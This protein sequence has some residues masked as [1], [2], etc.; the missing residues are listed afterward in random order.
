[1]TIWWQSPPWAD[2]AYPDAQQ[3]ARYYDSGCWRRQTF[4]DDL[5][6]AARERGEHPAIVAYQDGELA[7]SVT[8]AE[9]TVLVDRFAAALLEL[10]AGPGSIVLLYLPNCWQLS[11]LYLACIRIGAVASPVIP[12]LDVRELAYALEFSRAE[13]CVTVE[14]WAGADYAQ[15]LASAA[16]ST[17]K[18]RVV[19]GRDFESFFVD[20]PWERRHDLSEAEASGP[21]EPSL[22]LYTSGTTGR[23]KGVVHSQNTLH[24]AAHGESDTLTLGP[25]DVITIP[26]FLA[27]MAA[28]TYGC[29]MPV[30]LGATS[31]LADPN[32]D[33]DFLLDLIGAHGVTYLYAAPA[34]LTGML[35]AQRARPR[36]TG[37]LRRLVT[38]SA[39]VRPEL[40]SAVREAFGVD[41]A[42]LWGMTENGCVTI[43]RAEDPRGWAAHSDGRAVPWMEVRIEPGEADDGGEAEGGA[44]SVRGASQCLGYLGQPDVY[45]SCVDAGGWFST[46]DIARSDGREGIRILGRTSD[47]IN[48]ANGQ[49]ISTL[50]V[51]SVLVTHPNVA[52][53]VVVAYPDP[54]VPGADLAAA[55]VMV[56]KPLQPPTLADLH[57]HLAGERMARVLWPDRVVYMRELP[58]NS[59]GKVQRAELRRR[60]AT[61]VSRL[62]VLLH[63]A[64]DAVEGLAPGLLANGIERPGN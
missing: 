34:Y 52:D 42:A 39:P 53:V 28:G 8:Y 46:G 14:S 18:H 15:R 1:M 63:P 23:M 43:T 31:I 33:M 36:D 55:V 60:F 11:V 3:A 44:L 16:P 22:L 58:R 29:F 2:L 61:A 9:L 5:A 25:D 10:G 37:T 21:D 17:L 41:P 35:A 64:V 6:A 32:T 59:V 27:H 19:I 12:T 40:L 20:T 4:L 7:R 45:A 47:L 13:I 30:M 26:H 49:M 62:G 57:A 48:R 51:E 54:A 56:P 38:G 50:E 24:A